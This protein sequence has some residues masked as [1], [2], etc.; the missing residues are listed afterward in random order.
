[1]SNLKLCIMHC[2]LTLCYENASIW[3]GGVWHSTSEVSE[4]T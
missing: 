3:G 2:Q 4:E 1:M